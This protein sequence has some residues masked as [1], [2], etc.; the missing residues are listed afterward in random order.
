MRYRQN[1]V[2]SI[3]CS[4]ARGAI[5]EGGLGKDLGQ[6][7]IALKPSVAP[8][9]SHRHRPPHLHSRLL[10]ASPA[11]PLLSSPDHPQFVDRERDA[12]TFDDSSWSTAARCPSTTACHFLGFVMIVVSA[13]K[14]KSIW[15]ANQNN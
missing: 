12:T 13:G 10:T 14:R 4:G 1:R 6:K 7:P 8:S 15:K 5:D 9:A 2:T 3:V 11:Q